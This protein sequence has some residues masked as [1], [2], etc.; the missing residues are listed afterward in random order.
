M[1]PAPPSSTKRS[2][3]FKSQCTPPPSA[4]RVKPA[5]PKPPTAA[6]TAS[7]P[8]EIGECIRRD[9]ELLKKLGWEEVCFEPPDERR[10]YRPRQSRPPRPASPQVLQAARSPRQDE[11]ATLE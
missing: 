5:T 4:K 9:A 7:V 3:P 10:F 8:P 2:P 11:H 1:P 6:P